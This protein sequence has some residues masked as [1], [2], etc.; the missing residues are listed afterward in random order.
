MVDADRPGASLPTR[1]ARASSKSPLEIP[2]VRKGLRLAVERGGL[3]EVAQQ[4][5][6]DPLGAAQT[7]SKPES[8]TALERVP[9]SGGWI[10]GF[11][12]I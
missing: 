4:I 9:P 7:R 1:A 5:D 11:P 3:G 6:V 10:S 8:G 12:P 2:E